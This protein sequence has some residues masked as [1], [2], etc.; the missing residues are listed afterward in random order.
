MRTRAA[1]SK[2]DTQRQSLPPMEMLSYRHNST[3]KQSTGSNPETHSLGKD[4]LIV[5]RRKTQHTHEKGTGDCTS[6]RDPFRAIRIN[7][8]TKYYTT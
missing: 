3:R 1:P 6:N 4:D 5:S 8:S 2:H 7:D